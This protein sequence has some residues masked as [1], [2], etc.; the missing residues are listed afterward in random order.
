MY[1]IDLLVSEHENIIKFV[2][3]MKKS[4]RAILDG[5]D[6]DTDLFRKYVDFARNYAD[7]HHHGKE[8]QILFKIMVDELP[9]VAE[10]LIKNGMLVEHDLGRLFM[11]N[12]ESALDNYDVADDED[13]K[14][15]LIL[16]IITNSVGYGDL[17]QRHIEKEDKVVY[18]FANRELSDDLKDLVNMKTRAFELENEE[19]RVK[20][21]SWLESIMH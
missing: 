20:F 12:L 4:C 7:K 15:E 13:Y 19:S 16:D 1:G 9:P 5:K 21:E 11:A 8:E 10:K 2:K 6:V 14:R 17:L 18:T 3:I